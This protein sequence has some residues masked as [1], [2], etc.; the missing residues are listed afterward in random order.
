MPGD[1]PRLVWH[2][3]CAACLLCGVL[4][5]V[6]GVCGGRRVVCDVAC[7]VLFVPFVRR[8]MCDVCAVRRVCG[9]RV[10]CGAWCGL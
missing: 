5:R 9:V 4:W 1:P 10:A 7:G 6:Y 3:V 8:G 2:A